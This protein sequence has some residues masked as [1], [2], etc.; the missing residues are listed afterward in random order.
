MSCNDVS[1]VGMWLIMLLYGVCMYVSF[2]VWCG[3]CTIGESGGMMS[4][5]RGVLLLLVWCPNM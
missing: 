5:V 4:G 1:V 2:N 3:C